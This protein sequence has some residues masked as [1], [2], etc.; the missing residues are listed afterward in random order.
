MSK[1][2]NEIH[3]TSKETKSSVMGYVSANR[4]FCKKSDLVNDGT[5]M[6][7]Y[8]LLPKLT[9]KSHGHVTVLLLGDN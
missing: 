1:E 6:D 4:Q 7:G 9:L 8:L 3:V 5:A 2:V